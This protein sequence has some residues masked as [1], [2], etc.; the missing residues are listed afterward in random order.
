MCISVKNHKNM[1]WKIL[2]ILDK[3]NQRK[4][5]QKEFYEFLK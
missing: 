5:E 1:T 4:Y 2:D 3:H